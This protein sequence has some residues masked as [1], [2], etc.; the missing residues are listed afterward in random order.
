[1]QSFNNPH[2]NL[3]G[4]EFAKIYYDRMTC[5]VNTALDLFNP[6]V[7]CTFEP[8]EVVGSY[9]W[10]IKMTSTGA[11]KFEYANVKG[12][13]QPLNNFDVL[14]SVKGN[15]RGVGLWNQYV[16]SWLNFNETFVLER[17][18]NNFNIKNYIL[19]VY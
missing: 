1:M 13:S 7:L 10:L 18:G 15:L 6:N 3:I 8:D 12:S 19:R 4:F 14:V 16:S 9:N 2:Y 11:A 5:G 17:H